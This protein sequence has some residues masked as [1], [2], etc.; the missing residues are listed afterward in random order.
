MGTLWEIAIKR[1]VARGRANDMPISSERARMHFHDAG[2]QLLDITSEH[3]IAVERL[4]LL[5]GDPFDRILIAQ[6]LTE[7]LHL[8]THDAKVAE[9]SDTIIEV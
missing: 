7:P 4:P 6:A 8:L 9:Y 2:Y 3:A 5:H 1:A